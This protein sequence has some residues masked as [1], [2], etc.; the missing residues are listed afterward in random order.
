LFGVEFVQVLHGHVINIIV[1]SDERI[2]EHA[3]FVRHFDTFHELSRV[4]R[5]QTE[6]DSGDGHLVFVVPAQGVL[7]VLGHH[8]KHLRFLIVIGDQDG[9]PLFLHGVFVKK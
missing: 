1:I 4:F 6:V 7:W 9:F 3:F 8:L 2:V 5:V